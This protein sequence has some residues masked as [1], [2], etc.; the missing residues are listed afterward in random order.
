MYYQEISGVDYGAYSS[1][2]TGFEAVIKAS[3]I[4]SLPEIS[5]SDIRNFDVTAGQAASASATAHLSH[6]PHTTDAE[7][8]PRSPSSNLARRGKRVAPSQLRAG[9]FRPL[10]SSSSI[11]V[12]YKIVLSGNKFNYDDVTDDLE[13]AVYSG[14]FQNSLQY[15]AQDQGVTALSSATS[16]DID[17]TNDTGSDDDYA[18]ADDDDGSS[19]SSS[20]ISSFPLEAIIPIVIG[21]AFGVILLILSCY[22]LCRSS[23]DC[24][25]KPL[26]SAYIFI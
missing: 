9:N 11:F 16:S 15:F 1:N 12:N 3:I 2:P 18:A 22:A 21:G 4:D 5:T 14:K 17:T 20:T 7:I 26:C 25:F 8:N 10:S 23:S 13:M 24:K 19:G 6:T